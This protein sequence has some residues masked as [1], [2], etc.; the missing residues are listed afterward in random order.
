MGSS[1]MQLMT[2]PKLPLQSYQH[3]KKNEKVNFLFF[4]KKKPD[5][6]FGLFVGSL[7]P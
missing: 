1:D 5:N 2:R 7:T 3:I 4:Q 6:N